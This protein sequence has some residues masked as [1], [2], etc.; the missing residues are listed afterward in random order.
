MSGNNL[1]YYNDQWLKTDPNVTTLFFAITGAKTVQS[2]PIGPP[3]L[4]FFDAITQPTIDAFLGVPLEYLAA[5]FDATSM[6]TDA[7]GVLVSMQGQAAAGVAAEIEVYS[8]TTTAGT[9]L[10]A[11][12]KSGLISAT[13]LAADIEYQ[14]GIFGDLAVKCHVTGIDA[15]TTGLI[16]LKL[17]W[18]AQ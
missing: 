5:Q 11:A 4:P 7:F 16:V 14:R 3:V 15:L 2:V 13:A 1:F 12:V 9:Q 18:I 8:T 17:Y 6:G 10:R